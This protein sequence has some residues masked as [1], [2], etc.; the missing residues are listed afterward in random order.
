MIIIPKENTSINIAAK[1]QSHTQV[2]YAVHEHDQS[3]ESAVGDTNDTLI[4]IV[5]CEMT[6]FPHKE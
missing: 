5:T 3:S 1:S 4:T 2:K 6:S